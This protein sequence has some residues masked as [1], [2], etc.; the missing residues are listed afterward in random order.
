MDGEKF[1][2]QVDKSHYFRKYDN[3]YRFISYFQQ[4]ESIIR[5]EP[6]TILEIGVGNKTVSNYLKQ[7]GYSVTTCDFDKDLEPDKVGDVRKLPFEDNS[8]DTVAA[9]EILEHLPFS[10]FEIALKELKRVSKKH[11]LLS[12]P[13]SCAYLQ[14]TIKVSIPFFQKQLHFSLRFPYFF[15]KVEINE[16]N[17]EH[18]WEMGTKGFSKKTMRRI[19]GKYFTISDEFHPMLNSY[20]YFFVLKK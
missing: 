11:V 14:G 2:I 15:L 8:F 20:H 17:H 3:V 13:Y 6:E 10:D 12:F 7:F 5:T 9:C 1:P 16:K 18:Y 19:I 4:I